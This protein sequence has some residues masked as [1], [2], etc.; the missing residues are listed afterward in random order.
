MGYRAFWLVYYWL[1][2]PFWFAHQFWGLNHQVDDYCQFMGT[3]WDI[4]LWYTT[5][6]NIPVQHIWAASKTTVSWGLKERDPEW[7]EGQAVKLVVSSNLGKMIKLDY[8]HD[9]IFQVIS[10][11]M[12]G[13]WNH[14]NSQL[15][16]GGDRSDTGTGNCGKPGKPVLN[17][18]I[19][20]GSFQVDLV[21]WWSLFL[22]GKEIDGNTT[23]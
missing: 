18:A 7:P 12:A 2:I 23:N 13:G 21:G 15:V 8:N 5:N 6:S 1:S 3:P 9:V 16:S 22:K 17:Q 10:G 4:F 20:R 19:L 11:L 14:W